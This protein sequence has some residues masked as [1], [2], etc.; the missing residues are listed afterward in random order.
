M[1]LIT[2]SALGGCASSGSDQPRVDANLPD[3]PDATTRRPANVGVTA[4]IEKAFSDDNAE[5]SFAKSEFIANDFL[6]VIE[7]VPEFEAG[8]SK[9]SASLPRTRYGEILMEQMRQSGYTL[10]LGSSPELPALSYRVEL[11][12]EDAQDL[13][14]FYVS[15]GKVHLKR[16]YEIVDGRIAPVTQM[17]MAGVD[18]SRLRPLKPAR[19]SN[20]RLAAQSQHEQSNERAVVQAIPSRP[21]VEVSPFVTSPALASNE[22]DAEN[23]DVPY[24]NGLLVK[25]EDWNPLETNMFV[26]GSSVYDP[27]FADAANGYSEISSRVLVFPN[28]SLVLGR[29]NKNYLLNLADK[30]Q[31]GTDIVRVIGCSHGQTNLVE[32]NQKLARGRAVRVREELVLAGVQGEAVLHEACWAPEHFDEVMP[33]RGVV[34]MHLRENN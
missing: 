2:A 31:P 10:V 28:D 8:R 22:Q 17:L 27:L 18:A 11:P 24:L 25:D 23:I 14:T 20:E 34:V 9:F 4:P 13:H 26:T 16:S 21:K 19:Q 12:T 32:G 30:M 7:R 29:Q 3:L 5:K 1:L 33:R 6:S 15:V